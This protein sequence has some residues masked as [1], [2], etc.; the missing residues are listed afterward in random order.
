M[1]RKLGLGIVAILVVAMMAALPTLAAAQ[2]RYGGELLAAIA[3]DAPSFDPHSVTTFKTIMVIAPA[4]NTLLQ[5]SP[6]EYPKIIGDLATDWTISEDGLTYTFKIHQGVTFHDGSPLTSADIKAS[7]DKIIW[8]PSGSFS[9]RKSHFLAVAG[10][11]TPGDHTVVFKLKGP[12]ASMLASLASPWN[13]IFPKKYLDQ[14]IRY[15]DKKVIGSGPFKFKKNVK[16]ATFELVKNENY[17]VKGRPYLDSV[18]FFM[19]KN[20]SARAKSLRSGRVHI[21]F[22]NMP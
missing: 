21:E 15:F 9:A 14:D 2:P 3:G 12:S 13:V 20:L 6:T 5:F 16:G 11:E 18:K 7:F 4:Y 22:R 19:I 1:K 8:P 10:I 17:W